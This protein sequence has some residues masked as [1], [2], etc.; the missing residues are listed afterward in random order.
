MSASKLLP[1]N[2]AHVYWVALEEAKDHALIADYHALMA[3]D[4]S[5]RHDRLHF[6]HSRHEFLLTRA[7]VRT[8]LSRYAS[9]DPKDWEFRNNP[10]GCPEIA[11]PE[12]APRMRFNLSNTTGLVAM[13]V[14]ASSDV[15]VD[16]E[17]MNRRTETVRVADRYFSES[18]V[19]AL[20]AL[21]AERQ[22]R[23]FFEYW[24]LKEAY[25]KARRMGSQ[26]HSISFRSSWT[27]RRFESPSIPGSATMHRRGSSR[28]RA[29]RPGTCCP[30]RCSEARSGTWRSLCRRSCRF[31]IDTASVDPPM[32]PPAIT[33]VC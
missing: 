17:W 18:E 23:R 7:L 12:G 4:E 21:P 5:V 16:V 11:G 13:I 25:I 8:T 9:V 27:S 30:R 1:P 29:H 15:G 14:A 33:S 22:R 26:F 6:E 3:K 20:R 32:P 19:A 10:Y 31:A 28:N 2:K 24:T